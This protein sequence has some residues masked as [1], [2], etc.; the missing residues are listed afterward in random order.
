MILL[1]ATNAEFKL[2]VNREYGLSVPFAVL[3]N[4]DSECATDRGCEAA[5]KTAP[6]WPDG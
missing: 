1:G 5:G 2:T 4:L 3:P 6:Q